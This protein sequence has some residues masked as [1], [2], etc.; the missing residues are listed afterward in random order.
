MTYEQGLWADIQG[1]LCEAR[2]GHYGMRHG[3]TGQLRDASVEQYSV[4]LDR[5]F[6]GLEALKKTGAFDLIEAALAGGS[7]AVE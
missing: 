1:H 2:A 4:A 5:L 7:E 3:K 6:E